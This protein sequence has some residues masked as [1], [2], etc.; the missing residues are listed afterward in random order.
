[1]KF[2]FFNNSEELP[3]GVKKLFSPSSEFSDM[4]KGRFL[5]AFDARYPSMQTTNAFAGGF[6]F[7]LRATAGAV[8][9]IMIIFG[10]ASV[11]ADTT[12]VPVGNALYPLKRLT[13]TVRLAVTPAEGKVQLQ[14]AFAERRV[15]EIS[16][17]E[18]RN[19]T[20]TE[21]A[22]LVDDADASVNASMIGAD[23]NDIKDGPLAALCGRIFSTVAT[24]SATFQSELVN[25]AKILERFTSQ[26][27]AVT[28][29]GS[30]TRIILPGTS[31]TVTA[32]ATASTSVGA[33]KP[34]SSVI[35]PNTSTAP[36]VSTSEGRPSI[37]NLEL[38]IRTYLDTHASVTPNP[39]STS[40]IESQLNLNSGNHDRLDETGI[41][42]TKDGGLLKNPHPPEH[43]T[44]PG[45]GASDSVSPVPSLLE[46]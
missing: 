27:E 2:N 6:G 34:R 25:H 38:R 44:D 26:C 11:Y 37:L 1:M 7:A 3:K 28:V 24:S 42:G 9:A 32:T 10:G 31:T 18:Q 21:I 40:T 20:S 46:N 41:I 22:T 19:P 35:V 36:D 33:T 23:K 43:T 12:N 14:A 30:N 4:A 17:L 8:A 5:A 39:S 16:D 15:A 13:E 45:S 29:T